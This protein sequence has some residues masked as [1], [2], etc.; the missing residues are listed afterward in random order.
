MRIFTRS[1]K[2]FA[3]EIES[4][5]EDNALQAFFTPFHIQL[6]QEDDFTEAPRSLLYEFVA[7]DGEATEAEQP[8]QETD[9]ISSADEAERGK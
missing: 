7:G 5:S 3:T 6:S 4:Y 2:A 8:A 9:G 1:C